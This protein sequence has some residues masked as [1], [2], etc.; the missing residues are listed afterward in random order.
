MLKAMRDM[1]MVARE[2]EQSS[3][4]LS[5]TDVNLARRL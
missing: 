5:D 2:F 4:L 1:L 3:V